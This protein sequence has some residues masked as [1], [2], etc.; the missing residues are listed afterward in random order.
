MGMMSLK[1]VTYPDKILSR[2]ARRIN[3]GELDLHELFAR[4]V[5]A[6]R[7]YVGVGLAAPQVGLGIRFIVAEERETGEKRPYVNP[8]IIEFS[9]DKDVGPEGCLSFPGLYGDVVRAKSIKV[10]FQDLDFNTHEEEFCGFYARVL[11]HEI[12]HLNGVLLIDR[13]EDGLYEIAE[14]EEDAEDEVPACGP[15]DVTP[16]EIEA[17]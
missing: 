5:V 10:R 2:P 1:I 8:Q 17:P 7:E 15:L 11:Q 14:G 4:M 12:D 16:T 3:P 13:A 9:R 6:M